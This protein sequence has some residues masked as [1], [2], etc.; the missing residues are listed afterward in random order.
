MFLTNKIC[1]AI[2]SHEVDNTT[3]ADASIIILSKYIFFSTSTF[4]YYRKFHNKK[5]RLNFVLKYL[6]DN[7][8]I[9]QASNEYRFIKGTRVSYA[10]KPPN[11]IKQNSLS[12]QALAKLNLNINHYEQLWQQCCMPKPEMAEKID[13]SIIDYINSY[14]VDYISI[15]HRLGNSRDPIAQAILKPGLQNGLIGIDY[16]S[17]I[18]SLAPEHIISFNDDYEIMRQLDRLCIRASNE[19]VRF[20]INT[21]S[22][23]IEN[24]IRMTDTLSKNKITS[25]EYRNTFQMKP[26]PLIDSNNAVSNDYT[27][28]NSSSKQ[29]S[30][31]ELGKY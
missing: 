28:A 4:V 2:G 30:S 26:I 22:S 29:I 15:L 23:M 18:F 5:D 14:L 9:Y 21:E 1:S 8:L 13:K 3:Y 6:V 10:L 7:E 20:S 25:V 11:Q 12:N 24:E 17:N 19:N 16:Y 31:I 27:Q